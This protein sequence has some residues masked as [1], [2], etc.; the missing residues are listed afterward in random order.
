MIFYSHLQK[1]PTEYPPRDDNELF[2]DGLNPTFTMKILV[3]QLT[4]SI[5]K[6]LNIASVA[7]SVAEPKLF[8]SASA[9]APNFKKFQLRLRQ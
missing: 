9:P 7:T 2:A 4:Y 3:L 5:Y 1:L 8:V 6:A